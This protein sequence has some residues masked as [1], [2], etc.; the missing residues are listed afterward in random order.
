[1]NSGKVMEMLKV[2]S[3]NKGILK[4]RMKFPTDLSI[5]DNPPRRLV[6]GL[7]PSKGTSLIRIHR[8]EDVQ[9]SQEDEEEKHNS[10]EV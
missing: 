1:M 7:V 9:M 8:A 5:F 2:K 10:S 4:E 6:R 3:L